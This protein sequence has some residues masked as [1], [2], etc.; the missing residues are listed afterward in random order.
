MSIKVYLHHHPLLSTWI[1]LFIDTV[2]LFDQI[3]YQVTQGNFSLE[4]GKEQIKWKKAER[5]SSVTL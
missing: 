3:N 1:Y 5:A 2:E 4:V